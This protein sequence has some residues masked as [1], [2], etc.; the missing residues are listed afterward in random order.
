MFPEFARL[1]RR[2]TSF[3]RLIISTGEGRGSPN[4][5]PLDRMPDLETRVEDLVAV[6]DAAGSERAAIIGKYDG[7]LGATLRGGVPG[8]MRFARPLRPDGESD[9]PGGGPRCI[10]STM[11]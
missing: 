7:A 11:S 6:M 10:R 9:D 8:A 5:V 3:G 2:L 4:P 1:L